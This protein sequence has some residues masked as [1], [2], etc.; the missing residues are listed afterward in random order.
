MN[1]KLAH[2]LLDIGTTCTAIGAGIT[3][4]PAL[5]T[6]K[7]VPITLSVLAIIGMVCKALTIGNIPPT[8]TQ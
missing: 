7:W 5:S 6:A 3:A 1:P 4:Q 8:S 2:I